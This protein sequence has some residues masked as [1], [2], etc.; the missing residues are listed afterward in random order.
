MSTISD[1]VAIGAAG[2]KT[3]GHA[4]S[5]PRFSNLH[6]DRVA[7]V[8]TGVLIGFNDGGQTPLVLYSGQPEPAAVPAASIV[9]L[10]VGHVGKTVVLTFDRGDPR[11]PLIMGLVRTPHGWPVA[12][13]PGQVHIDVDGERLVVGAREQLVLR[14]GNASITLTK[15]GKVLI[16]GTYVSTRASG[17][18]RIKGGSVQLN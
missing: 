13:Q 10:H 17:V 14:C 1:N 7:G 3:P 4:Q 15:A 11:R 18:M 5:Q 6:D 16:Q 8:V 12:E 9:D 2:S